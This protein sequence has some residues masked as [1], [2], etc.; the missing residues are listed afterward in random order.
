[1]IRL[2]HSLWVDGV[3]LNQRS[4][5]MQ[6]RLKGIK[7]QAIRHLV[8]WHAF[9]QRNQVTLAVWLGLLVV[10]L[11]IF[12]PFLLK[13]A[14]SLVDDG[15]SLTKGRALM[16]ASS[17]TEWRQTVVE[18]HIGRFRPMYLLSFSLVYL[19]F[20][21]HPIGLWFFQVIIIWLTLV[22]MY[23]L[24]F[25][26]SQ[27]RWLAL[28]LSVG[29]LFLPTVAENIFRVGTA[30]PKQVLCMIGA[31]WTLMLFDRQRVKKWLVLSLVLCGLSI[32]MKETS[33]MLIP[34]YGLVL[35]RKWLEKQ[36]PMVVLASVAG[37][38]LIVMVAVMLGLKFFFTTGYAVENFGLDIS[39]LKIRIFQ[40]RVNFAHYH[41]LLLI[42]IIS[43]FLRSIL[44][45]WFKKTS[46][47]IKQNFESFLL[48]LLTLLSLFFTIAWAFQFERYLYAT[49]AFIVILLGVETTRW[50]EL[51]K[52]SSFQKLSLERQ[53]ILI[54]VAVGTFFSGFFI[55]FDGQGLDYVQYWQKNLDVQQR[56]FDI[57]QTEQTIIGALLA[58]QA[59]PVLYTTN[60]N[61][62]VIYELGLYMSQFGARK[63][64]I[65]SP[66]AELA[67]NES[68]YV[69]DPTPVESFSQSSIKAA[70]LVGRISDLK[71]DALPA[72]AEMLPPPTQ[73]HK[74]AD[75]QAWWIVKKE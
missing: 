57:N 52:M 22:V 18:S 4:K 61:Y 46:A 8:R 48:I 54:V 65:Y 53:A 35:S 33:I 31:I 17:W 43:L 34:V 41:L 71:G 38:S 24:L 75:D 21:T 45:Y 3:L 14:F 62:E 47:Y 51:K 49:W 11:V 39:Q 19:L 40:N 32:G 70:V 37:L 73:Y 15:Y 1:M 12:W 5:I 25:H 68:G 50:L 63:V 16:T 36:N 58:D 2:I 20:G 64:T 72:E 69:F 66:S 27:R 28:L 7:Q 29:W 56:S 6:L 59:A 42:S 55:L 60:D 74:V 13:P 26:L 23:H 67:A 44:S 9:V 10:S 30:E